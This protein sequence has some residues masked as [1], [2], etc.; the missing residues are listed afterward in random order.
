MSRLPSVPSPRTVE[1]LAARHSE[2]IDALASLLAAAV[3]SPRRS[4]GTHSGKAVCLLVIPVFHATVQN[5]PAVIALNP[6]RSGTCMALL[7]WPGGWKATLQLRSRTTAGSSAW[8][9]VTLASG[10][11]ARALLA[12]HRRSREWQQSR[13]IVVPHLRFQVLIEPDLRSGS[14]IALARVIDPGLSR[15]RRGSHYRPAGL[16]QKL[17]VEETRMATAHSRAEA[18]ARTSQ[19]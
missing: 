14:S 4:H 6:R 9:P 12:L 18:R 2:Q 5:L 3:L 10:H 7:R 17:Q 16:L 8:E 19:A 15:L 11:A 13:L 1:R